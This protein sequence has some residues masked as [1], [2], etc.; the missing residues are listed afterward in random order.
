MRTKTLLFTAALG[1]V[2]VTSAV[3]QVYSVNAVGYVNKT[4]KPGFTMIANPLDAGQGKNT[5]GNV[6]NGLPD[7][8]TAY[9]YGPAGWIP[10][11]YSTLFGWDAPNMSA[12]PGEGF[13]VQVP[14]GADV[15][16]TFVGEVM[17]GDLKMDL[18]SGFAVVASMVPQAGKVATDLKFP[19]AEGDTI[20]T[21]A[22]P[23]GYT[24]VGYSELFGWS[25]AEPVVAVGEAF[26]SQKIGAATW[27]R[28]FSVNTP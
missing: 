14:A 17:Q 9:K 21:Y 1:A 11:N 20:Y 24:P 5:V 18:P 26:W 22:E 4:L 19:V 13:F 28:T 3:A 12:N 7:G 8:S 27:S 15:T 16:L 10:N 25:P 6:F 2:G 23:A